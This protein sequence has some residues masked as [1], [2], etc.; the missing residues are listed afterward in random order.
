MK[1]LCI[2]GHFY[3]PP[4]EEPETGQIKEQPSAAPFHDWNQRINHECY[5]SNW[6]AKIVNEQGETTHHIDNYAFISYNF[7]PTLLRWLE[8]EDPETHHAIVYSDQRSVQRFGE[9][10]AMAQV[11]HHAILPLCSE[12]DKRTEVLWGLADFRYRFGREARGIWLAETAVDLASLEVLAELGVQFTLLAPRQAAAVA[13]IDKEDW[14]EVQAHTV[15]SSQ[16]YLVS[17]PSG[18]SIVVFFYDGQAAQSVAFGGA[19]D[20][21]EQFARDLLAQSRKLEENGLLHFATDG[22]SYGHHHRYGEMAL[23]YCLK[24]IL[25]QSELVLCNYA[26]Y[27]QKFPPKMRAKIQPV[28]SWSCSHGIGRWSQNCGCVI[29][30]KMAGKQ[31]WRVGLR[32]SLN[33]LRDQLSIEFEQEAGR[34]L[35]DPWRVRDQWKEAELRGEILA[36]YEQFSIDEL[37]EEAKTELQRLYAIQENALKMFTSCGWFFDDPAGLET[38]QILKYAKQAIALSRL[39]IEADFVDRIRVMISSV[40]EGLDGEGI[41]RSL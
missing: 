21:G 24:T 25:E 34:L 9:G 39:D 12:R 18:R 6:Q 22:E 23:G 41:W 13:S 5:R 7:G 31:E 17:L 15:D 20:N 1:Y 3:Q 40:E 4:R 38:R 14:T 27:I 32:E 37:A 28:S 29:D 8:L 30:P 33:W 11:Y 26:Q 10:S 19:L 35:R 16:P 36:L 2:H